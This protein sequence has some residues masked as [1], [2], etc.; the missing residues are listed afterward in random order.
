[1]ER[2]RGGEGERGRR[3]GG[4]GLQNER[5]VGLRFVNHMTI[6]SYRRI[7]NK[8]PVPLSKHQKKN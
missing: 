2:G 4:W 3:G 1:M 5:T 8:D 7:K 6:S